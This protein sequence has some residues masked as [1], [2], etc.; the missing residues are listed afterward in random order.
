GLNIKDMLPEDGRAFGFDKSAVG[1]DLSYV[2]LAKYMEAADAALDAAIAPHAARPAYLRS[3]IPAGGNLSLARKTLDGQTVFLKA[4]KYD[5]WLMPIP[6]QKYVGQSP[7]R[8]L[9]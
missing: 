6:K 2:Q 9:L 3:H 8:K 7:E 5:D 4:F 1:L